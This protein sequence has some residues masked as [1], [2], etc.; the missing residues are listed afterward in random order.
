MI[1][2][3]LPYLMLDAVFVLTHIFKMGTDMFQ[4]ISFTF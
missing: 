2:L 4:D 1:K 3:I